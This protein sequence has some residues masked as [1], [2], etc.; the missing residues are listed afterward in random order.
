MLVNNIA[1]C[2]KYLRIANNV[3][4]DQ[5]S[6]FMN[7]FE[8]NQIQDIF[9]AAFY[10][11]INARY[12]NGA[13][14]PALTTHEA[15][16]ITLLQGA[17]VRLAFVKAIP[18]LIS[19]FQGTGF[20]QAGASSGT[21]KQLYEWQKLDIENAYL[22]DGWKNIGSAQSYLFANRAT[23]EFAT[24]KDSSAEKKSR[25]LFITSARHFSEYIEIGRSHRT[26]EALKTTIKEVEKLRIKPILGETLFASIKA[27]LL[28]AEPTGKNVIALDYINHAVAN[29]AFASALEKLEFKIDE[30]GARVISISATSAGKAKVKTPG[31]EERKAKTMAACK[32]A[33]FEFLSDLINYLNANAPDFAGYVVPVNEALS[34]EETNTVFL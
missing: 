23:A 10:N 18:T 1:I 25:A 24:W 19:S 16:V 22:E 12:N 8:L 28:V 3:S 34:N 7:E 2:Q 20:Y 33:A 6:Q 15:A 32:Q 26:Y 5:L 27:S 4:F 17:I 21:Q 11:A 13:P 31:E 9:G 30:E 29:L 14:S